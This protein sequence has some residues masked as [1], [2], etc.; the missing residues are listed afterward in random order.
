MVMF[1]PGGIASLIMMHAAGVR[2][3]PL[4]AAGAALRALPVAALA[5]LL[6]AGASRWSR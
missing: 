6:L 3:R 5:V 1:A 4:Q 2:A